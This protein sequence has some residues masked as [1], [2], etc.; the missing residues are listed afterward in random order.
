MATN[1][2]L[3]IICALIV[4]F[5]IFLIIIYI[6]SK[7]TSYPYYFNVFFC[8]I[9]SLNNIIRLIHRNLGDDGE[10][11]NI[12]GICKVQAIFLT[13]LDK[14][15]LTCVCSYSIINYLGTSKP[16]FY[17][18]HVKIVFI[19]LGIFNLVI[20][21]ISTIIFI[22]QGYS[23]HSEY[24]YASTSN[25]VK[26]VADSIITGI[27]FF[28]SLICLIVLLVNLIQLKRKFDSDNSSEKASSVKYHIF[29]FCFDISINIILFI[30]ILLIINKAVPFDSFVKDL[31]Y[32]LLCLIIE[33][34]FT[35]NAEFIKEAKNILTCKNDNN[36][37]EAA[38]EAPLVGDFGDAANKGN[39]MQDLDQ[40]N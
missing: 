24:C 26:K 37:T 3:I 14:L 17:N 38:V 2:A 13:L 36:E 18:A 33:I 28:I 30:Y 12:S 20:S 27:L 39:N 11:E 29:R 16:E 1:P 25:D 19:I 21:I 31:I 34:F 9:I 23:H 7:F 35:M 6:K 8:I 5:N 32:I 10:E 22:N 40:Y 15:I 4:V